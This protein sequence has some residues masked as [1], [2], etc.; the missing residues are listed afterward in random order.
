MPEAF[1]RT[2]FFALTLIFICWVLGVKLQKKQA[3]CCAIRC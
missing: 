1:T 3:G 2:P